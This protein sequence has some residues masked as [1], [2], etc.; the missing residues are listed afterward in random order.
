V[1]V[2]CDAPEQGALREGAP[3]FFASDSASSGA[4]EREHVRAVRLMREA[5]PLS[6][7]LRDFDFRNPAL[8]LCS[9]A[10][11]ETELGSLLEQMSFEPGAFRRV[12]GG[13]TATPLADR[14]GAT[15]HEPKAGHTRAAHR[16]LGERR[17]AETVTLTTNA[18]DLTPGV[19]FSLDGHPHP[20]LGDGAPLL[21]TASSIE[22]ERDKEWVAQVEALSAEEPYRPLCRTPRPVVP[23]LQSALVT[24]PRGDELFTDEHGRVRVRFVWDR[25][26]TPEEER[27]TWVR[28]SQG[29][30]GAGYG[31]WTLPR[32]G[33][34]VLVGFFEGNPDEPVIVGRAPNAHN[35]APYPLP[36]GA[37][38]TVWRSRS[39]PGADGFNEISFDDDAGR[40][41]F[42]QRAQKDME[43]QVLGDEALSVGGRRR[44]LVKG[45]WDVSL[46]GTLRERVGGAAHRTV[47]GER[48]ELVGGC[49]SLVVGGDR[50][51]QVG[52]T[53]AAESSGPIHLVSSQS[54][55]LEAP[56]ITLKGA[57]GFVRVGPSGVTTPGGWV[58]I[59]PG[60]PARG[61]WGRSS[62]AR[63]ARLGPKT[64]LHRAEAGE[65]F[66]GARFW[67]RVSRCAEPWDRQG[68]RHPLRRDV[69]LQRCAGRDEWQGAESADLRGRAV[70]GARRFHGSREH[71]QGGS[72]L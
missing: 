31:L 28:V 32:V 42:F 4:S 38:K 15:R 1:L 29:W 58:I 55:V 17:A 67:P 64:G 6:V 37:T 60:G 33:Q 62:D 71:D 22:G 52:G 18:L 43:T 44:Q 19:V 14:R 25:A 66:A 61:A 36:A 45:D 11:Q 40:E 16:L 72:A 39:T 5:H 63:A 35:P 70:V 59:Q 10:G 20:A 41:R 30:A 46:G 34:E 3:L 53:W 12:L 56:D 2:L 57:G 65:A 13:A 24:G 50:M 26:D 21:V 51:E 47:D 9:R 8:P 68:A 7:A 27:S 49:H 23:G 69:R 48:R 54:I